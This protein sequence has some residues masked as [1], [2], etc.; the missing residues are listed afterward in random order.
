DA[1]GNDIDDLNPTE[2]NASDLFKQ[3]VRMV[4]T[5][6]RD[7]L[8]VTAV[9]NDVVSS[10]V[11]GGLKVTKNS[12]GEVT[13]LDGT[14]VASTV[15][16]YSLETLGELTG[17]GTAGAYT[18][19]IYD[20]YKLIVNADGEVACAVV[21]PV[22]LTTVKSVASKGITLTDGNTSVTYAGNNVEADLTKGAYVTMTKDK[23]GAMT[24]KAAETMTAKVDASRTS[25]AGVTTLRV[26]GKWYTVATEAKGGQIATPATLNGFEC[27]L[28]LVAGYIVAGKQVEAAVELS[29]AVMVVKV[30]SDTTTI[31]ATVDTDAD[32]YLQIRILKGDGTTAV[33]NVVA[34]EA[35][36]TE[37]DDD[38]SEL[39]AESVVEGGVY[40]YAES[41]TDKGFYIL[42]P[43]TGD[44][45]Y[46]AMDNTDVIAVKKG[47]ASQGEGDEKVTYRF[48][49]DA[50]IFVMAGN[51]HSKYAV[52]KGSEVAAWGNT[53]YKTAADDNGSALYAT[54]S[55]NGFTYVQLG[56]LTLDGANRVPGQGAT[57]IPG[58]GIVTENAIRVREDGHY[59]LCLNIWNG[60]EEIEVMD[61]AESTQPNDT[62]NY[63]AGTLVSYI[64]NNNGTIK[65]LA[66]VDS[67]AAITAWDGNNTLKFATEEAADGDEYTIT[68]NT[69][70]LYV[71][72]AN[73]AGATGSITLATPVD[74]D[75]ATAGYYANVVIDVDEEDQVVNFIIV[76][77]SN[78]IDEDIICGATEGSD[79]PAPTDCT[80]E[81]VDTSDTSSSNYHAAQA[82][83]CEDDGTVE[84]W[85]CDDCSKK[86]DSSKNEITDI[87]DP[88]IGHDFEADSTDSNSHVCKN[89]AS[90][91]HTAGTPGDTGCTVGT[92]ANAT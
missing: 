27:D 6:D 51:D 42:T 83:T 1:E 63:P 85:T 24:V 35:P 90:H 58:L 73:A 40:T 57:E 3:T 80:H 86:L 92:C 82:P 62:K 76:E 70:I 89:D 53:E 64:D 4:V 81:N 31:P 54:K 30:A 8:A 33:L 43:Y 46:E 12:D 69:V 74:V 49:D 11:F 61:T 60:V 48:A 21:T 16:M 2:I 84:Y 67:Y 47:I 65:S 87:V 72:M 66:A 77:V 75:D 34:V 23:T 71:D 10:G 91:T 88:A 78:I 28:V 20:E 68:D 17:K 32:K 52:L 7:I 15:E 14:K 56:F 44:E 39:T 38:A 36:A 5:E 59:Y 26:G 18:G 50:T 22:T 13:K 19:N 25:A 55:A 41:K 9:G 45:G 79:V 37:A 29:D